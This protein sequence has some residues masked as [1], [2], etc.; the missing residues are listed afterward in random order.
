MRTIVCALDLPPE[1]LERVRITAPGFNIIAGRAKELDRDVFRQAEVI[2]GW[3]PAVKEECFYDDSPLR[4][5]QL[6]TAGADYV[7]MDALRK[8]DITLTTAGGVHPIPMM[9]TVFAMLLGFTRN[10]PQAIR[11][12]ARHNW[13][14]KGKFTELHGKTMGIIGVGQI[15]T[16]VARIAQAFGMRVLG[17]RRSIRSTDHVDSLYTIEQ[18]NEV[19][20]ECDVVVNILP[21]TS[22]TV[23][24]YD[25][26]TFAAMKQGALFINV[27]R[28]ASVKTSALTDALKN[29]HLAGAGLDVFDIEPLPEDHPLWSMDNVI[30]TPHIGGNTDQLKERAVRLFLE[31]LKA[32]VEHGQPARSIVDYD[33]EY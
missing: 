28:G 21:K 18:L 13:D 23:N 27:G 16:E 1:L 5:I 2:F 24:L 31:N 20:P 10:L 26:A 7:P 11:N 12:Q 6:W 32:Y 8:H 30:I 14:T 3:S 25:E 9:E 15:G 17:V 22:Q 33:K 4:W 19:L 29:G